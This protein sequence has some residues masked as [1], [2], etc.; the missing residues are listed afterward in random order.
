MCLAEHVDLLRNI[1][2]TL[3]LMELVSEGVGLCISAT[4]I[5]VV[6]LLGRIVEIV[7]LVYSTL[8]YRRFRRL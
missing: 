1:T 4:M 5:V 3:S 6:M 2:A 7:G 8:K